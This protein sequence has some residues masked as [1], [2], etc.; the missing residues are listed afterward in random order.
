MKN[1]ITA[2]FLFLL[3]TTCLSQNYKFEYGGRF[4]PAIKKEKLRNAQFINEIM[5]E[6]CRYVSLPYKERAHLDQ[7]LAIVKP[8]QANYTYPLGS[9]F[10][11]QKD[12]EKIIEYVSIEISSIRQGKILTYGNT[13][14]LLTT[15]QKNSLS[16]ADLGTDIR[17]KI[18]FKYKNWAIDNSS[19]DRSTKEA[20]YVVTVIP[21]TEATYPGGFKQL[22][23]YL[24]ENIIDKVSENALEKIQQA[25]V[26][27]NVDEDGQPVNARL[28]K[29]STDP[30]TD[31]LIIDAIKKMPKWKPA[32]NSEGIIVNEEIS[33]PFRGGG[34]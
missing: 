8:S 14:D 32:K 13:T 6:F 12:Y 34:C 31:Q 26:K 17:I 30:K 20:Q 21:E 3:F 9:Y 23:A 16:S 28:F 24:T 29:T 15:E 27:F 5:P 19:T 25:I 33:I 11:V 4:S 22:T 2:L 10:H 18:R 1:S 7:L